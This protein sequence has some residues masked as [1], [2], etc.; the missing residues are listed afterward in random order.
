MMCKP[1]SPCA[2]RLLRPLILV[3][4]LG[5]AVWLTRLPVVASAIDTFSET[6][7]AIPGQ[8]KDKDTKFPAEKTTAADGKTTGTI[9][10]PSST[11]NPEQPAAAKSSATEGASR[12]YAAVDKV[13]EFPGGMQA[14]F[15]FLSSHIQA[16]N[17]D[18]PTGR[19]IV[20]FVVEADG[21]I[22]QAEIVK[23]LSP[24][25]DAE[26]LRVVQEM[27]KWI[28]AE[29]DGHPVASQFVLPVSY[30]AEEDNVHLFVLP[31]GG[32]ANERG[33]SSNSSST[34]TTSTTTSS[35]SNTMTSVS[36]STNSSGKNE[37]TTVTA[38][39][40]GVNNK[41][42]VSVSSDSKEGAAY[43]VYVNG[44]KYEGNF[45]DIPSEKVESMR[46]DKTDGSNPKIYITLKK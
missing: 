5:G 25:M 31:D 45:T 33:T 6:S 13:A 37:T 35:S 46:V 9:S 32:K 44:K 15:D 20:R 39:N 14:L 10:I 28:P 12:P 42:S 23:G 21:K 2:S 17:D 18:T 16:P 36:T 3:P 8:P 24:S 38:T 4:V 40:D 11:S 43:E 26:A 41:L 30:I 19:V 1:N 7:L 27:P 34:S 29:V 22:G